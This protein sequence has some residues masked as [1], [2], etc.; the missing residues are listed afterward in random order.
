MLDSGIALRV[1][2]A[3]WEERPLLPRP[4]AQPGTYAATVQAGGLS[5][6]SPMVRHA[7]APHS[8]DR[9]PARPDPGTRPSAGSRKS[10][11][12]VRP[13]GVNLHL[14][15]HRGSSRHDLRTRGRGLVEEEEIWLLVLVVQRTL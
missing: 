14:A 5:C 8:G 15:G 10:G 7:D 1:I 13:P 4:H 11:R 12:G 6:P 2:A 3:R 9:L